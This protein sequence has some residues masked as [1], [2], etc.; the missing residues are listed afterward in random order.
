MSD[1]LNRVMVVFMLTLMALLVAF[2]GWVLW[3]A[4]TGNLGPSCAQLGGKNVLNHYQPVITGKVTTLIPIYRCEIPK[5][6]AE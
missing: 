5:E 2:L 1:W 4:I 3:A 6:A